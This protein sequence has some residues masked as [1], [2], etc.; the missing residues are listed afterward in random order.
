MAKE[1]IF[2]GKNAKDAFKKKEEKKRV[3][4]DK[5]NIDSYYLK[6]QKDLIRKI[7]MNYD[8]KGDEYKNYK[9]I[10]IIVKQEIHKKMLGYKQQDIVKNKYVENKLITEDEII[11][12]ILESHMDCYYCKEEIK[13]LYEQVRDD[14]QWTLDRIDNDIGHYTNNVVICCLKCNLQRRRMDD[15]KFKFTKQLKLKKI[16]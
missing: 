14:K 5:W 8:C 2:N 7:Y 10:E 13:I 12:K 3:I 1:I 9:N 15:E 4:I 16:D 11:E 6:N